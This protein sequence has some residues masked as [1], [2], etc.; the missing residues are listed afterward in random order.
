MGKYFGKKIGKFLSI[1]S[2]SLLS[3][4]CMRLHVT[5]TATKLYGAMLTV[6]PQL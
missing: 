1:L 5:C 2:S 4:S 6:K 3:T